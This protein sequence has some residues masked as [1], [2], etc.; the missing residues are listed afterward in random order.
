M[1]TLLAD[2][3]SVLTGLMNVPKGTDSLEFS[4]SY[5][6][7]LESSSTSST[8]T[9]I[10]GPAVGT[11]GVNST[12][13]G[14]LYSYVSGLHDNMTAITTAA[15]N[16]QPSLNAADMG[17]QITVADGVLSTVQGNLDSMKSQVENVLNLLKN[18]DS[19]NIN[20][21]IPFYGVILGM[22]CLIIIAIIFLK[23]LN[24]LGCRYLIYFV[25]LIL[26]FFCLLLFVY[27][28]VLAILM[29][30]LFYTCSYFQDTFTSPTSFTST[31]ITLLGSGQT[32]LANKFAECFGGTNK[33]MTAVNP[34]LQGYISQLET[35]VFNSYQY[36]FT[37]MT[38][39]FSTKLNTLQTTINNIGLGHLPDFDT[40]TTNGMSQID[41][42]NTIANKSLYTSSCVQ[43]SFTSFYQDAWVPGVSSSYQAL[44]GCQDKVSIDNTT[45]GSDIT[46][47]AN[48]PYSRCLDAFSLI[49]A[50]YRAGKN[51]TLVSNANT[52]YGTC[53]NFNSFLT[54]YYTNYVKPVVDAIGNTVDDA[55]NTSRLAG[56]FSTNAKTPVVNL[57]TE[58]NGAVKTLFTQVYSNLTTTNGL[59]SVFDPSAG[60]LTGLDCRL[61]GEDGVNAKEALC[62]TSFNRIYF[63]LVT[64]GIMAF[65][66]FFVLCCI[67]CFNVRHYKKSKQ[68]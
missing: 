15:S 30:S 58:M 51:T 34:T 24:M 5:N 67:V 18:I 66:S 3:N 65:A 52:R 55:T 60:V 59:L 7:P 43:S 63:T 6:S 20:Y 17:A 49:S 9:G 36:D 32:T 13:L 27:A 64:V 48:C 68:R 42:F 1:N 40:S 35:A 8:L 57:A 25:S 45:C 21:S 39:T 16:V 23:C 10:V 62:I 28:V 4:Q 56:R 14:A 26:F 41:A 50:Y 31:I 46:N 12:Q 61:L 47:T 33:F 54:N 2:I 22:A 53:A 11:Y 29:P 44:V 37:T 38:N 19:W